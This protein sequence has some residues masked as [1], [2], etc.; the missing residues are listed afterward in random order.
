MGSQKKYLGHSERAT[1]FETSFKLILKLVEFFTSCGKS[2]KIFKTLRNVHKLFIFI[3]KYSEACRIFF[4]L[5]EVRKNILGHSERATSFETE[6]KL[7]LKLVEFFTS[8]GKSEKIFKTHRNV[9]KLFI[10][11]QKYFEVCR[12]FLRVVGSQ[13]KY[14]GHSGMSTSFLSSFKSIL[15][16]V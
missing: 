1:S 9:H 13:K 4:K 10:F 12:I 11:I 7:I 5:W 14:L 2:E 15:K 3:Q 6:F 8:Y 16:L